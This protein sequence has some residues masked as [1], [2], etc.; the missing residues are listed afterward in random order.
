MET[1]CMRQPVKYRHNS[2]GRISKDNMDIQS[3]SKNSFHDMSCF[4][5]ELT[6][7]QT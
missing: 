5:T 3:L 7:A 4:V 6:I 1:G 2:A